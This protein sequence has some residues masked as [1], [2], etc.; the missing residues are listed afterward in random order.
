MKSKTTDNYEYECTTS[1]KV[2]GCYSDLLNCC[3][4]CHY[5][6]H[7]AVKVGIEKDME[8]IKRDAGIKAEKVWSAACHMILEAWQKADIKEAAHMNEPSSVADTNYAQPQVINPFIKLKNTHNRDELINVIKICNISN[9]DGGD[10]YV[11]QLL[12]GGFIKLNRFNFEQLL[13][14]MEAYYGGKI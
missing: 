6:H 9:P 1:C 7:E 10:T 13:I 2:T 11:V 8:R 14:H 4:L 5:H 12:T 3:G